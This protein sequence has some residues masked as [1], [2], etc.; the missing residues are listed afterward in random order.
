MTGPVLITLPARAPF[1][2]LVTGSRDWADTRRVG[3][4]LDWLVSASG[5]APDPWA[6]LVVHGMGGKVDMAA[7]QWAAE[8]GFECERHLPEW[9]TYGLGAGPVR[10]QE[11]AEAGAHACLAFI[12]PCTRPWHARK[13]PHDS[14]GAAGC[15][16]LA[17]AAGIPVV[18][19]RPGQAGPGSLSRTAS[20]RTTGSTCTAGACACTP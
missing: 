13:P 12:G 18:E 7:D 6:F 1:R 2:I 5:I 16:Q 17:R 3:Q 11:M 14:H 10:N 20:W 15:A 4:E 8:R 9:D 19:I